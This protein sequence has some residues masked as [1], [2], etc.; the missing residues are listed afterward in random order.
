[1]AGRFL[2]PSRRFRVGDRTRLVRGGGGLDVSGPMPADGLRDLSA[3]RGTWP[4]TSLAAFDGRR[5]LSGLGPG[6]DGV[7]AGASVISLGLGNVSAR[8]MPNG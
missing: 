2:L 8:F 7:R 1:M 5:V 4:I 3:V 6:A